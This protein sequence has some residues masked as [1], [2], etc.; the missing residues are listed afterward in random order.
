MAMNCK[1]AMRLM[2]ERYEPTLS[3][4]ERLPLKVHTAMCKGCIKCGQHLDVLHLAAIRLRGG[5]VA[6]ARAQDQ[7]SSRVGIVAARSRSVVLLPK[8]S[9][10]SGECA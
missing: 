4:C 2:S 1:D 3:L 10:R 8:I 7:R 6:R 9:A 5:G